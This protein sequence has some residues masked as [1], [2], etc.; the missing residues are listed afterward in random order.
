MNRDTQRK[1]VDKEKLFVEELKMLQDII[2]RMADNSF[3]LKG[4]TVTLVIVTMTFK[5]KLDNMMYLCFLP[6]VVFGFLDAYYLMMERGFRK[7][8]N[9]KV[10]NFHNNWI[11]HECRFDNLFAFKGFK[12]NLRSLIRAMRSCSIWLFYGS[13]GLLIF[14]ILE[15]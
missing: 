8:F 13:I 10:E 14:L 4:W 9:R 2:K 7:I 5:A 11:E 12:G 15:K 1:Y 6:I 3:K